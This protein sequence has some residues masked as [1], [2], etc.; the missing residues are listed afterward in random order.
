[1]TPPPLNKGDPWGRLNHFLGNCGCLNPTDKE[2][3]KYLVRGREVHM[4]FD[5][6]SDFEKR[7]IFL[8]VKHPQGFGNL[9]EKSSQ[10]LMERRDTWT[11]SKFPGMILIVQKL[12]D[13]CYYLILL[14]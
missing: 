4:L 6:F 12:R 13:F 2:M 5:R 1:M 8:L 10:F 11:T 3:M 14:F 7:P 9:Q